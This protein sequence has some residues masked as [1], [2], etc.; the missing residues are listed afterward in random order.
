MSDEQEVGSLNLYLLYLYF[1]S[2][3][4]VN[5]VFPRETGDCCS[6]GDRDV[7]PSCG[8]THNLDH[9]PAGGKQYFK[10]FNVLHLLHVISLPSQRLNN[11]V[12]QSRFSNLSISPLPKWHA[13][14]AS[15]QSAGRRCPSRSLA[16]GPSWGP[17]PPDSLP[18]GASGSGRG[19]REQATPDSDNLRSF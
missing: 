19:G 7:T 10:I 18:A 5:P 9:S 6:S 17:R 12:L 8:P 13:N 16:R 11:L 3:A 14:K 1:N 15:T 2:L 4:F